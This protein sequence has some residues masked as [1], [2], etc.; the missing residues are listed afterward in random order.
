MDG[1]LEE[2]R[3][4][5]DPSTIIFGR[6]GFFYK[7]KEI[8]KAYHKCRNGNEVKLYQRSKQYRQK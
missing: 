8:E 7:R 3:F 6:F 4:W 2:I 5:K 1:I